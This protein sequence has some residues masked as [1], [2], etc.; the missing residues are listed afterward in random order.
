MENIYTSTRKEEKLKTGNRYIPIVT[1]DKLKYQKT[2][3]Y[4][5]LL[6]IFSDDLGNI[7]GMIDQINRRFVVVNEKMNGGGVGGSPTTE[8]T[9]ALLVRFLLQQETNLKEKT[10]ATKI[11]NQ[12]ILMVQIPLAQKN[13]RKPKTNQPGPPGKVSHKG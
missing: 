2:N 3:S 7:M 13:Q 10:S 9:I 4:F 1:T 12:I 11:K 5:S 8:K 6:Y